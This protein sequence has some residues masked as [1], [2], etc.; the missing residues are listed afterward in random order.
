MRN[1]IGIKVKK[2]PEG[3]DLGASKFFGTPTIPLEWQEDFYDDEMFFCQISLADLAGLDREKRL[4]S[5]GYLYVFIHTGDGAYDL[6]AD[7]RYYDGEPQLA[8][9]DFN[10]VVADYEKFTE[11]YLMEF[12]E[13]DE[14]ADCTRLFG[15]P[16]D[17]NY[18]D[19]PPALLMQYDPLD[20]D[21]GFLDHL[22]GFIYFVF[23]E[24]EQDLGAVSILEMYS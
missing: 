7:V 17:W 16:S 8:L 18:E 21:M 4:P 20:S 3:Y 19:E 12:Y 23:G 5:T 24:D 9:D 2:A 22:D 6:R 15:L 10:G 11:A 13:A 14:G 1:A